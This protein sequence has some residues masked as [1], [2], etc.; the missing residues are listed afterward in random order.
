MTPF[1][2]DILFGKDLRPII[3]GDTGKEYKP[4]IGKRPTCSRCGKKGHTRCGAAKESS[5]PIQTQVYIDPVAYK[6]VG[7]SISFG[8]ERPSGYRGSSILESLAK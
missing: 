4:N 6:I 8:P 1:V 3:D 2:E 7:W 5:G